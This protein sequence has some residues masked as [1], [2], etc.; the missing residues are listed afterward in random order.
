MNILGQMTISMILVA[1]LAGTA[2]AAGRFRDYCEVHEKGEPKLCS[3]EPTTVGLTNDSDDSGFMDFKVSV[4]YQLFPDWWTRVQ[5]WVPRAVSWFPS[6][7]G[8]DSALYFA[9]TGRFGQY[10]GTRDSSPVVEKLFN[11]KLFYRY[12]IDKEHEDHLDIAFAHQSNGQSIDS[13]EE[14]QA[15]LATSRDEHAVKDQLSRGWDYWE[16]SLKQTLYE[17]K[18]PAKETPV[19][20]EP[21]AEDDETCKRAVKAAACKQACRDCDA[22]QDIERRELR[23]TSIDAYLGRKH[24]LRH[25]P[26]QGRQENYSEWEND[27]EGRRLDRVSG[28]SAMI[29][30]TERGDR[31]CF[32]DLKVAVRY[33]TGIREILHYDTVRVEVGT[34]II[35]LPVSVWRQ[36]GY[37]SDL[38]QY[39]KRVRSY[40]MQVDIGSF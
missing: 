4:R 16:I 11:P 32:G 2:S 13:P 29:K 19:P 25:G 21:C 3:Y 22:C 6:G 14:Y 40:G 18:K 30:W 38:A 33:E 23:K 36:S 17:R 27:P 7:V 31:K 9:F 28:F 20:K 8:D 34:K 12:W 37:N 5:N 10:I 15:A 24:F 35:Q 26:L 39:F 1:F